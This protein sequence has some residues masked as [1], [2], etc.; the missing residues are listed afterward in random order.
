MKRFLEKVKENFTWK[1]LILVG[2]FIAFLVSA[3]A[4]RLSR[5]HLIEKADSG[6][7]ETYWSKEDDW[8]HI[9][10]FFSSKES[11]TTDDILRTRYNLEKKLKE[12]SIEVVSENPSARLYVDAYSANGEATVS[13]MS[14]SFTANAYGV[15]GDFFMFHPLD[16][17]YGSYF[18]EDDLMDDYIIIDEKIAWQ[19]FGSSNV[20]GKYV[21][22]AD[23]PHKI[24][25]VYQ[26]S[27]DEMTK[28]AGN[29]KATMYMSYASLSN[30]GQ[31]L[32]IN[33]YEA[34]MPNPVT[35]FASDIMDK[36]WEK[37]EYSISIIES[38]KRYE[39][40]QLWSVIRSFPERSMSKNGIIY[41]IWENVA[42]GYEDIA[43]RRL[44]AELAL[45]IIPTVM[46]FAWVIITWK[47]IKKWRKMKKNEKRRV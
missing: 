5:T 23:T 39:V 24:I 13:Y 25:G 28:K 22:I 21:T 20:V 34:M 44:K 31:S 38:S 3:F 18:T 16:L 12:A 41:P 43:A 6:K 42:R 35:G 9:S 36:V 30:Y 40:K 46:L 10:C 29:E 4:V 11:I 45:L 15:G 1:K 8:S 26:R 14:N 32:G 37:D 7:I 47:R 17:I 2:I 19:L 33:T 27:E